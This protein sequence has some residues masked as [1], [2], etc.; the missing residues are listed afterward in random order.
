MAFTSI[1][2]FSSPFLSAVVMLRP[3]SFANV[4]RIPCI[5]NQY[6]VCGHFVL[7][8]FFSVLA[9]LFSVT[10]F[11][12]TL[13]YLL[14]SSAPPC[15]HRKHRIVWRN[16]PS[17][18]RRHCVIFKKPFNN[19][20]SYLCKLELVPSEFPRVSLFSF[21]IGFLYLYVDNQC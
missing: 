18:A 2:L 3:T 17:F 4:A 14:L 13:S 11:S 10:F 5:N 20:A 19:F 21:F 7:S 12:S 16:T 6:S 15:C 1:F 9:R 8:L